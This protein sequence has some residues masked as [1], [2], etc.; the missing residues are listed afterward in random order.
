MHPSALY[1][2]PFLYGSPFLPLLLSPPRLLTPAGRSGS[3]SEPNGT[4][5]AALRLELSE[6]PALREFSLAT[7]LA[8][9]GTP[10]NE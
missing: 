3:A 2:L 7:E 9:P 4:S 8:L 6:D 10:P 1:L 5:A